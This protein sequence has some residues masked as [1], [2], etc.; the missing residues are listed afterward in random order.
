MDAAAR[1]SAGDA[2]AERRL[3][4]RRAL[5]VSLIASVVIAVAALVLGVVTGIRII[6][7]DGAYMAI[8]LILSWASLQAA[9]A[10]ASGPSRRYPFG[11]DALA[12]LVVVIQGLA[13]AGTLI[14]AFG[15]AL[16]VIRDGGSEVNVVVISI[17]GLVTALLGFGV[18]WWL[19]RAG[20]GSDLVLAEAAQWRAGAVLSVIMFVGALV[21]LVLERTTY[22][23]LAMYADPALVIIACLVLATIPIKLIRS[24]VNELLEGAPSP[25]L[26]TEIAAAIEGVRARFSLP[27]PIVRANKLGYKVYVEVDFVVPPGTWS[28]AQEDD[29]RRAINTALAPTELDVWAY[30]AITSDPALAE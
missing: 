20:R 10:A 2:L 22:R 18:A 4:E 16:V 7:F 19:T 3:R 5:L 25:E 24:G 28:L 13:L 17:Y 29:V 26:A 15:D 6:L 14:L 8:G 12:P 23:E 27:E 11:R 9:R 30:V 21:V 1:E